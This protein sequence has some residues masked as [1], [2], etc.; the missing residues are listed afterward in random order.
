MDW[1][2]FGSSKS[3]D[4]FI[5]FAQKWAIEKILILVS[6]VKKISIISETIRVEV[7][8][9]RNLR[10][11]VWIVTN[12]LILHV[13]IGQVATESSALFEGVEIIILTHYEG[14]ES[15]CKPIYML[16]W[17]WEYNL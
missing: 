5:I 17:T 13:G 6:K 1:E 7:V 14:T 3:N 4:K 10:G 9:V 15:Y 16:G 11:K 12:V 8:F 2:K